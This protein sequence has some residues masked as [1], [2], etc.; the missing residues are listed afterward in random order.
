MTVD[1]MRQL[2]TRYTASKLRTLRQ[3]TEFMLAIANGGL[4]VSDIILAIQ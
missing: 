3:N 1:A 4:I 2:L